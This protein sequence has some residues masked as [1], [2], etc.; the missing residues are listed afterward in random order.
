MIYLSNV[1]HKSSASRRKQR[2]IA[3]LIV[4]ALMAV[5][6]QPAFAQSPL[7]ADALAIRYDS[8]HAEVDINYGILQRALSFEKKGDQWTAFTSSK[9]EVWQAGKAVR[10]KTIHDTVHFTGTR[11]ALDSASTEKLLGAMGFAVPY[12]TPTVAAFIWQEVNGKADTIAIPLVL[13][14]RDRSKFWFG[15]V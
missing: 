1:L 10:S 11:A 2:S 6:F 15:G 13:P 8:T 7:E 12:A 3:V 4:L 9:A 14:D 5:A